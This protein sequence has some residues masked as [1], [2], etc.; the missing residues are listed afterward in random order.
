MYT[1]ESNKEIQ[2]HL[3]YFTAVTEE[4]FKKADI[5][6]GI[7]V[8]GENLTNLRFANDIVLFN[9]KNKRNGKIKHLNCL[10]S[11]SLKVCS[12]IR[13]GKT[14]HADSDDILFDQEKN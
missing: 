6:E 13:E 3:N 11:E 7:N 12:K 9:E 14:N 2:S 10:N 1:E 4:V 8:D 5:S